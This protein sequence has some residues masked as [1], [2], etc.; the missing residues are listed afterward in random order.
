M[1]NSTMR[2]FSSAFLND[3]N[4][5]ICS[6]SVIADTTQD[7]VSFSANLAEPPGLGF[8]VIVETSKG[9]RKK[10]VGSTQDAFKEASLKNV[11]N[12]T[13]YATLSMTVSTAIGTSE[14]PHPDLF[15]AKIKMCIVG[16]DSYAVSI[17]KPVQ[18]IRGK[19][20]MLMK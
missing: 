15:K 19:K 9:V 8:Y 1:S 18:F 3:T 6:S 13:V 20:D 7:L 11:L 5:D 16:V 4:W 10:R 14:V 17:V 2:Q 12:C